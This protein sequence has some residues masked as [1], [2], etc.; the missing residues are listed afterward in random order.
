M[1]CSP[2]QFYLDLLKVRTLAFWSLDV[3]GAEAIVLATVDPTLF[4]VRPLAARSLPWP[5]SLAFASCSIALGCP[6]DSRG[7]R[8]R[9]PV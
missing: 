3:E 6:G 7:A 8:R 4:K 1:P 5:L 9:G 2:L